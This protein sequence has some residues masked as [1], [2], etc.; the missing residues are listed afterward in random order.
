MNKKI[1]IALLFTSSLS[2]SMCCCCR[3]S[4]PKPQTQNPKAQLIHLI[5]ASDLSG[6][7]KFAHNGGAQF[8]DE[9]ACTIAQQKFQNTGVSDPSQIYLCNEFLVMIMVQALAPDQVKEKL[10][11]PH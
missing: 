11:L 8:I 10:G 1:L 4:K 7:K 6:V 2:Y 9:N 3:V 5:K